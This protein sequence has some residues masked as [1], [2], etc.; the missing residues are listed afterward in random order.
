V[1]PN[2]GVWTAVDTALFFAIWHQKHIRVKLNNGLLTNENE[3]TDTLKGED[4]VSE[5]SL[6][7]WI[8]VLACQIRHACQGLLPP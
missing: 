1:P 7:C 6:K 8:E 4:L 3:E 5:A 2:W